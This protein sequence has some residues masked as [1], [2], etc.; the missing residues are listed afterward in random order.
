MPDRRRGHRPPPARS[1]ATRRQGPRPRGGSDHPPTQFRRSRDCHTPFVGLG[2]FPKHHVDEWSVLV[3]DQRKHCRD[4]RELKA[5]EDFPL[6]KGGRFGRH[7]LCKPC[8]AAQERRRYE[9]DRE[10]LLAQMQADPARRVRK[11]RHTLRRKY[12]LT[13]EEYEGLRTRQSGCCAVCWR[14]TELLYVDHD[15][16]SGEVRGLLCG[17]CNFGVGDFG[18]DAD[19]CVQCRALSQESSKGLHSVKRCVRCGIVRALARFEPRRATCRDCVNAASRGRRT[20][21]AAGYR[22]WTYGISQ[23]AFERMLAVQ[24]CRCAICGRDL[25]PPCVDHDHLTGAIRGLLCGSCNRGLGHFQDDPEPVRARR[26][27]SSVSHLAWR[28]EVPEPGRSDPTANRMRVLSP[29]WVQIP[30]SPLRSPGLGRAIVTPEAQTARSGWDSN[31]R[32][33]AGRR[34]SRPLPSST[35]PPLRGGR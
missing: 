32:T 24:Q 20:Y 17:N 3:E 12:G 23:A 7:P 34:L 21:S 31:P 4:C 1:D 26:P 14:R 15:H 19:R 8:R 33:L 25:A 11:R 22:R 30:P 10:R 29:P 27:V 16:A 6:Q 18:D 5:L 2:L 13:P 28:G 9:R 35:R